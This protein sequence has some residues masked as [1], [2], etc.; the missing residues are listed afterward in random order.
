MTLTGNNPCGTTTNPAID[1]TALF[2][3]SCGIFTVQAVVRNK[4]SPYAWS[5]MWIYPV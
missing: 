5:T 4:F 3:I 2:G 1:I